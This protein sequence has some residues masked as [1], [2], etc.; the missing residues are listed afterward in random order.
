MTTEG[1]RAT[2]EWETK[3]GEIVGRRRS[4][5]ELAGRS[6]VFAASDLVPELGC[7]IT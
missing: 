5:A 3:R 7:L 6:C 2:K 1:A 4:R